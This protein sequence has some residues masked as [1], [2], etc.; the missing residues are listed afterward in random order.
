MT[1]VIYIDSAPTTIIYDNCCNFH[2]YCL[3]REPHYL[4]MDHGADS[5]QCMIESAYDKFLA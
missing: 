2:Q 3:N 4:A 5:Y 1:H